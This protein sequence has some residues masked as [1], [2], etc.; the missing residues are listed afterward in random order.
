MKKIYYVVSYEYGKKYVQKCKD[1][2]DA[3]VIADITVRMGFCA[4]IHTWE[5]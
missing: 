1:L 5:Y 2:H 3:Y 4:H